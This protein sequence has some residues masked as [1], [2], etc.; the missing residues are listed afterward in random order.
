MR[1]R[2]AAVALAAV[3]LF[4]CLGISAAQATG[5]TNH[6]T[7][8]FG[9]GYAYYGDSSSDTEYSGALRDDSTPD[10]FCVKMQRKVASGAWLDTGF[11][12]WTLDAW[13]PFG[14]MHGPHAETPVQSCTHG[15]IGWTIAPSLEGTVQGIRF[16]AGGSYRTFCDS[17]ELCHGLDV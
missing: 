6:I 4:G 3:A 12:Q 9:E 14:P 11:T 8:S 10:G 2:I 5:P 1:T 15:G 17:R 16:Y 13:G 7:A